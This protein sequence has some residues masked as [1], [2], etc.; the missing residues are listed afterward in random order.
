V[1]D[2]YG[3]IAESD[4]TNNSYTTS[5]AIPT[6]PPNCTPTITCACIYSPTLTPTMWQT[7]T[8]TRTATQFVPTLIMTPT[9]TRTIGVPVISPTFTPTPKAAAAS[10]SSGS[11][12]SALGAKASIRYE[13]NQ[14]QDVKILVY[15]RLGRLIKTLVSTRKN[16]GIYNADWDGVFEDGSRVPA[17]I[18]IIHVQIGDYTKKLKVA[19]KK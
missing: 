17:G 16:S 10:V 4:E 14:N 1:A 2:Y 18:Y 15:N 19:V 12:I 9:A 5:V 11:V 6:L 3:V 13:L 8:I 7:P